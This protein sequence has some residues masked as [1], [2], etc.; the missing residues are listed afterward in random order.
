MKKRGC[1]RDKSNFSS[2][3]ISE[4][5][6]LHRREKP[7]T[8]YKKT[9]FIL[10]EQKSIKYVVWRIDFSNEIM[11]LHQGCQVQKIQKDQI[12]PQPVSKKPNPQKWKKRPNFLL[13][14]AWKQN[15]KLKFLRAFSIDRIT[16]R[17]GE[18]SIASLVF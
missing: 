8:N 6:W 5:H 10:V 7:I 15:L 16:N 17:F 4:N 13:K 11:H 2:S 1:A 3:R 14:L 12:W 9:F 18:S